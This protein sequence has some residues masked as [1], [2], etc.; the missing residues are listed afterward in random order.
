MNGQTALYSICPLLTYFLT[1]WSRVLFEK[2]TGLQIVKKFPAFYGTQGFI[3]AFTSPRNLPLP[4]AIWIQSIPPYSTSW[5]SVL[6]LSSHPGP[7]LCLWIIRNKDTL[8]RWGFVSPSP[9]RQAWGPP[10]VG[11]S[12]LFIQYINSCSPYWRPFLYPQPENAPCRGDSDPHGFA[13]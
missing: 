6:M 11:C 2:L 10:L 4:F 13:L 8:S 9:N 12:R 3:T 5:R 1:P 7:R